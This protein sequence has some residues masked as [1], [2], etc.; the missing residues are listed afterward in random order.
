[1]K[2]NIAKLGVV[3]ADEIIARRNIENYKRLSRITYKKYICLF[4]GIGGITL[5]NG[6]KAASWVSRYFSYPK[7]KKVKAL[8]DCGETQSY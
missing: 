5:Q 4:I 3:N 6:M 8:T 1:M 2:Q 7:R